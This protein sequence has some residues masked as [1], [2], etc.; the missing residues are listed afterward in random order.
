MN[1][2]L[3]LRV[4]NTIRRV[5]RP[6]QIERQSVASYVTCQLVVAICGAVRQVVFRW[7]G[8]WGGQAVVRW[9]LPVTESHPALRFIQIVHAPVS[10]ELC[11]LWFPHCD[12]HCQQHFTADLPRRMLMAVNATGILLLDPPNVSKGE[13]EMVRAGHI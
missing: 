10:S 9:S 3:L 13:F 5:W 4:L 6:E 1:T 12:R 7:Q 8:V 2:R 11:M